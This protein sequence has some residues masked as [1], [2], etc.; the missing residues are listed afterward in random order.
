MAKAP[1][2][3]ESRLLT[4]R[5][6]QR[7]AHQA[8]RYVGRYVIID[9]RN[10]TLGRTRLGLTVTKRYGKAHDRNRFKRIVREAFRLSLSSLPKGCDLN[11]KPRTEA[12][13]ALS[14]DIMRDFHSLFPN[15]DFVQ[16]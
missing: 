16:F 10:N 4:R 7:M 5:E 13:Q 3:K 9:V 1:F 11:V 2:P 15:P 8:K 12:S 14:L 6:F